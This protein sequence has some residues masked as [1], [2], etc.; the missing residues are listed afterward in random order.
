MHIDNKV[1]KEEYYG[2]L[3]EF[4][5]DEEVTDINYDGRSV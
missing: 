4:I 2:E 5:K 3:L 1:I